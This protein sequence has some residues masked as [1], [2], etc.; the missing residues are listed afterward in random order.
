M[1]I[2]YT[3]YMGLSYQDGMK[4]PT[5]VAKRFVEQ[6]MEG[7]INGYTLQYGSGHWNGNEEDTLIFTSITKG[8]G[9]SLEP[10]LLAMAYKKQ[11][12]QETVLI[13][14]STV[15]VEFI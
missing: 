11:F 1:N 5:Y 7:S 12:N 2:K 8:D 13:E 3:V 9:Q 15:N 10:K 6:F 14:K 4:I